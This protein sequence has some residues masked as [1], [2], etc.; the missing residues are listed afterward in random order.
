MWRSLRCELRPR[1][2]E[3]FICND[4][5]LGAS[6]PVLM[7][8]LV[9]PVHKVGH[10]QHRD[11][12]PTGEALSAD[13]WEKEESQGGPYKTILEASELVL[14][15]PLVALLEVGLGHGRDVAVVDQKV[16]EL[17]LLVPRWLQ[18]VA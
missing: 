4:G 7:A 16:D 2:V 5:F 8:P 9:S 11:R 18:F 15:Y 17:S 13:N 1:S 12:E 6:P 3:D 10:W 14:H